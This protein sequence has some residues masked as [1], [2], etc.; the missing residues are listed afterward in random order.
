MD[1]FGAIL[2]FSRAGISALF[3]GGSRDAANSGTD[4]TAQQPE[5]PGAQPEV[6]SILFASNHA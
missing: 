5:Q 1:K 2:S 3:R 6:R 4:A